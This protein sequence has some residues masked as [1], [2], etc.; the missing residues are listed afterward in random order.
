MS[1][2]HKRVA[3]AFD[4]R[5]G[6]VDMVISAVVDAQH[7]GL[8][9]DEVI[10]QGGSGLSVFALEKWLVSSQSDSKATQW[11]IEQD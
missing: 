10:L 7:D 9:T 3:I 11:I 4:G 2:T 1:A 8:A 5:R 6:A